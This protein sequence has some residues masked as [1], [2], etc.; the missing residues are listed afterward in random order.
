[1]LE[2]S[3]VVLKTPGDRI[4]N[5][6]NTTARTFLTYRRAPP[7]MAA[8]ELVVTDICVINESKAE[9]PP[10]AFCMIKKNLNKGMVRTCDFKR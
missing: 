10:H 4:A 2:D 7:N 1:M 8:N 3:R 5:V 9:R 6:S